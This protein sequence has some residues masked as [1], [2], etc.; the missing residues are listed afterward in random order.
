MGS[1]LV[2][3]GIRD[4]NLITIVDTLKS[5]KIDVIPLLIEAGTSPPIFW[6]VA[7]DEIVL[8]KKTLRCSAAFIRRDVFNDNGFDA[9]Y[10]ASAWFTMI[11]GWLMACPQIRVLNRDHIGK[12]TNKVYAL[13]LAHSCGL[14]IPRTLVS[15]DIRH[16]ETL[17]ML[18]NAVAKPITG[19]GYCKPIEEVVSETVL[20]DSV[21]STPAI[22]QSKHSGPDV[23]IYG[24]N[25]TFIGFRIYADKIDY[26]ESSNRSIKLVES[27]PT[28]T[29]KL[30][31]RLMT[32]L[33][34]NWCAADFKDDPGTGKLIFLEINSNPM[35]SVFDNV[36]H[37]RI[38]DAVVG[39]LAK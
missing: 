19:G 5:K 7:T 11:Q 17:N 18:N 38:V 8:N 36:A 16:L 30:L 28:Q 23:R 25:N 26:R 9:N 27:L 13:R 32:T 35:F 31:R 39:F 37:G 3:G 2:A 15:N 24:I 29:T 10:R 1:V 21:S 20:D 22:V 14:P 33:G 6:E 4:P 34:L 12:T